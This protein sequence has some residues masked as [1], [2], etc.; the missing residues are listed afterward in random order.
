MAGMLVFIKVVGTHDGP[1]PALLHGRLECGKIDFIKRT[2]VDDHVGRMPVDL[3]IVQCIMLDAGGHAVPL[4]ALHVRHDHP[5]RQIGVLAHILEIPAVER[6]A[7]DIHAGTQQHVF[8]AIARL[9][10]DRTAVEFRHFGI[11]GSGQTRQRRKGHAGV[12]APAGLVPFVPQHFGTNAVRAVGRPDFGNA[13]PRHARRAELGLRMNHGDFL[14]QGH[15]RQSILDSGFDG[16]TRI[17]IGG[18]FLSLHGC[19]RSEEC[20]K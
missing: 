9:L 13:Q 3:L 2:I 15:A 17:E 8:L 11:P 20:T 4:H 5:G 12:V 6:R 1:G 16:T 7:I 14:A 10:A 18:N 19:T